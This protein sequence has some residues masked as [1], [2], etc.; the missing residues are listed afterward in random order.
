MTYIQ[1]KCRPVSLLTLKNKIISN[2][3]LYY[4]CIGS[5]LSVQSR[6]TMCV[7]ALHAFY[8]VVLR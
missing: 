1:R 5:A 8:G 6:V 2:E 7:A 4:L 3:P